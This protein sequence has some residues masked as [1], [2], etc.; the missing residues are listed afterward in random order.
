MINGERNTDQLSGLIETLIEYRRLVFSVVFILVAVGFFAFGS[1]ARQ[2]DPSFP[3]RAGLL[4]VFY[5]GG[6][7][8][9]IEKLITEP[10][11]EELAQVSEIENVI[12]TSRDDLAIFNIELQDYVYNT[13]DAWDRVQDAVARAEL[14][15][16]R[17]VS[18]IEFDD[19]QIDMA[20][21]VLS[22]TGSDDTILL[23]EAALKLKR[24]LL[25]LSGISRIEIEGAPA[26][27]VIIKLDQDTINRL[28]ISR[29]TIADT[30]AQRNTI[31]PGGVI[32]S[33]NKN[34]R[35]NTQSDFESLSELAQT[36]IILPSGQYVSLESIADISIEPRLPL[37]NQVFQDGKRA[38]SLGVIAERGQVDI[39]AFGDELRQRVADF[40]STIAPLKIEESFFQADYVQDRLN[41]LRNNL[42]LSVL[43]IAAIVFFALGWRTGALVSAVLPVVSLITLGLYSAGGGIFHQMAVIGM[44]IS[45]GILIDNAI[46]VVE[47]I[48]TAVR[49]GTDLAVAIRDSMR[50]MAKPLLASTGT[51]VAAFIPLLLAKGGVGDFTRAVPTMI[52]IAMIVSYLLSILVL[53][54]IA[55]YWL[56]RSDKKQGLAFD[57]TDAIAKRS[58]SIVA[59]QP[60]R[61]LIAVGL[62]LAISAGM[63]PFLKQEFFPS[64]DR[65]QIVIDLELPNNT[66]LGVTAATSNDIERKLLTHPAVDT[67][68]RYVGGAGFRFYYNMGGAANESHIARFTVNTKRERDNQPLIDWVREELRPSYPDVTLIPR[69]LGQGPPRPAPI[70]IRVKH[71]HLETLHTASQQI[72]QQLRFTPGTTELR[73]NLDLGT[74]ELK[75]AIQD[76]AALSHGLQPSQVAAG[77]FAESRGLD[78]GQFRYETDPV[79]IRVRSSRGQGSNIEVV[80]NQFIYNQQQVG[81]PLSQLAAMQP[82]WTPTS[83]RHH[84]FDRTVTVLSQVAPGYAFNQ[85]L[86]EFRSRLKQIEL[87]AGVKI[88]YGGDASASSKSNSN[89]ASAAPLALGLLVFFMMF[90]FNSFRRIGIVFV[91]IP[92]AAVGVIPGLALSGQPFGFQSLLG[93]IALVGIVVNNAIV[94]IDV[95]DKALDDGADINEAVSLALQKRTAPILLTT[96]T[97]IFGLLPLALSSSTLWPPMAWAI[98][99]GLLLSTMLTL[100]AIPALCTL[101]LGRK[102]WI[103]A[104]IRLTPTLSV[105]LMMVGALF[106]FPISE[107]LQAK[108]RAQAVLDTKPLDTR[109]ELAS[110]TELET[111][112]AIIDPSFVISSVEN[113]AG[114]TAANRRA[115]AAKFDYQASVRKAWGPSITLG[116]QYSRRNDAS[117][118][119]LPQ[120]FGQLTVADD[121][122]YVYEAKISQPIFNPS[123]QRY[124]TQAASLRRNS[125]AL[126][127]QATLHQTTGQALIQYYN[128][129]LLQEVRT[130]IESLKVSLSSRLQRVQKQVDAGRV[131][132]TDQLQ[133]EVALN[134]V[135]QQLVENDS[136]QQ[137]LKTALR[138][139]LG[140]NSNTT[141]LL[142]KEG[143]N[144]LAVDLKYRNLEL[145]CYQRRDC[146]AVELEVE[147]I[148]A[149]TKSISASYLP[150]VNL[151]V[152]E[153]RSEGQL[154]APDRDRRAML[155]FSWPIFSGGQR[156][157]RKKATKALEA[158]QVSQLQTFQEGIK[159]QITQAE[160]AMKNADS[161]ISL[162]QA[163]LRL[164]TERL[165]L[166]RKRYEGGLL[167]VDELLDAEASLARSESDLVR[168]R[169]QRLIANTQMHSATGEP[170]Q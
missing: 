15:F 69:L 28:G 92:L 130:S 39:V 19:R 75:L 168:A 167:N 114:V 73:S 121:S 117:I 147:R 64:T 27:E 42:L 1:M 151:S 90:Q 123:V 113:N 38:V 160:S 165:R 107:S 122:A 163:S 40:K 58:S 35:L 6:T 70:E 96:A 129:L 53:P 108:E 89:I 142:N 23:E 161:Q 4:K 20:A 79:P 29:Q 22:V 74:P 115:D 144:S 152:A 32:S 9:Q 47:Y 46:V 125:A 87:P 150:S 101:V 84:N 78:A 52:V 120:P 156:N 13:A 158:A 10:L 12:S 145:S 71:Y 148:K 37:A 33:K 30:V 82:A 57:I 7:P 136:D 164:D 110:E 66:P 16:P 166:S 25:G 62:L 41:G 134:R 157:S 72:K 14:Q 8:S 126:Q 55:F 100:V 56:K 86:A 140:L 43:I 2:E 141:L 137:S 60:I 116:G 24:A 109:A 149:Q 51:T 49:K 97:T 103:T 93:V 91:S 143:L 111:Q 76:G 88:E 170:Y 85:V 59:R 34:I 36:T 18:R 118:I 67:I 133:V 105:S 11:E 80:E 119:E 21:A 138:Y 99:S 153:T 124:D 128:L 95:I 102:R 50:V 65:A 159:L 98:I 17:G 5:P 77:I 154:F 81:T 94:L 127:S 83:L 146:Q 48:E 155:E 139:S 169:L 132:K 63:A 3:Y 131:L 26:K 135:K 44:V 31:I 104:P 54:L 45:L 106:L 68:Y 112:V 61:V 162:A